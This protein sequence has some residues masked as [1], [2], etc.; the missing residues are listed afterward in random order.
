M[1]SLSDFFFPFF[2]NV[3]YMNESF[4]KVF[5]HNCD[6]TRLKKSNTQTF[7]HLELIFKRVISMN[8]QNFLIQCDQYHIPQ[9][10]FHTKGFQHQLLHEEVKT[11]C[12]SWIK[13]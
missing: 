7:T 6:I 4:I 5:S 11:D 1:Y 12:S 8:Q 3:V 10:S 2:K 13:F 9:N